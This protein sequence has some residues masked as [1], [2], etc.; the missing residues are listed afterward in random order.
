MPQSPSKSERSAWKKV[1]NVYIFRAL[2]ATPESRYRKVQL[3]R[4]QWINFQ[5][6]SRFQLD[7]RARSLKRLICTFIC[8][9]K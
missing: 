5:R 8:T 6:P 1:L 2:I 3:F 7:S 9:T 4:I